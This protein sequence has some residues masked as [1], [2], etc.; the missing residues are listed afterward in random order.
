[1][2]P[3][4]FR[5]PSVPGILYGMVTRR[6]MD[7]EGIVGAKKAMNERQKPLLRFRLHSGVLYPQS[8]AFLESRFALARHFP[9]RPGNFPE[10]SADKS[11]R[12]P[13][14]I[15][16]RRMSCMEDQL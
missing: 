2:V 12:G 8:E 7:V 9:F 10:C 16:S 14:V 6:T 13:E 1:M 4:C 11:G 5:Q 15:R 3:T